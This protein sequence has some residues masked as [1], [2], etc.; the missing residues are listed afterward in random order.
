[1]EYAV[2]GPAAARFR[3]TGSRAL[4]VGPVVAMYLVLAVAALGLAGVLGYVLGASRALLPLVAFGAGLAVLAWRAADR[5]SVAPWLGVARGGLTVA[6]PDL[7]GPLVVTRAEVA[8]VVWSEEPPS[9]VLPAPRFPVVTDDGAVA[10]SL[11]D[12]ARA[13]SL[14]L[15][16]TSPLHRP[17]VAVVFRVPR[18]LPVRTFSAVRGPLAR[19]PVDCSFGLLLP[20][21]DVAAVRRALDAAGIPNGA[22]L[23]ARHATGLRVH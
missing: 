16:E 7:T 5:W 4:A 8:F 10:G 12:T 22:A 15:L 13:S 2:A 23:P 21:P 18:A 19:Y 14:T 1:M 6:H 20:L 11:Y 3:L 9:Q 17:T